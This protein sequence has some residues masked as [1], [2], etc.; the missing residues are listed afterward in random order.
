MSVSCFFFH[1]PNVIEHHESVHSV[2]EQ[3]SRLLDL[4][5][6]IIFIF[7]I[8]MSARSIRIMNR[9]DEHCDP[10]AVGV[11]FDRVKKLSNVLVRATP[12]HFVRGLFWFPHFFTR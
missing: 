6:R 9:I 2:V 5:R 1:T 8:E 3:A 12:S 7:R 10:F 11:V 4:K